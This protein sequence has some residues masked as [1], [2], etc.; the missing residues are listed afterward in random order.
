MALELDVGRL[1]TASGLLDIFLTR[2]VR[3]KLFL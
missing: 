3:K 1:M 2:W